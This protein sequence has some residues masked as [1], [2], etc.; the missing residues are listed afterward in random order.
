M[1]NDYDSKFST[2]RAKAHAGPIIKSP[3]DRALW[4]RAV[5]VPYSPHSPPIPTPPSP[6]ISCP[7]SKAC[8][9]SPQIHSSPPPICLLCLGYMGDKY[10]YTT[11]S[12]CKAKYATPLH[13][14]RDTDEYSDSLFSPSPSPQD[15]NSN[16]PIGM[17]D[18]CIARLKGPCLT[19][20]TSNYVTLVSPSPSLT[21]SDDES[22]SCATP[23]SCSSSVYSQD[24]FGL[25]SRLSNSTDTCITH[26][27]SASSS[28]YS[29]DEFDMNRRLEFLVGS[30]R[31]GLESRFTSSNTRCVTPALSTSSP[32]DSQDEHEKES[33]ETD[34]RG[35]YDLPCVANYFD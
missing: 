10:S 27:S 22:D 8:V 13:R 1:G 20:V 3:L 26:L 16:A 18:G 11:C 33:A 34:T 9:S 25:E 4:R 5:Y 24:D 23:S 17:V 32:I 15:G 35:Y 21:C 28:V 19:N 30:K 12:S 29:Q 31:P 2:Y 7:S 14:F 6:D